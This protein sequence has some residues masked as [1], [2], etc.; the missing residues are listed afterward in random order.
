[1]SAY[2]IDSGTLTE[3]RAAELDAALTPASSPA[4]LRD[5]RRIALVR[6]APKRESARCAQGMRENDVLQLATIF[7][8]ILE[9]GTTFPQEGTYDVDRFSA[10]F[11]SHAAFV[12]RDLDAPPHENV[13][14]GMVGELRCAQCNLAIMH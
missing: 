9:E 7:D 6:V 10:Y 3:E 12:V 1:M 8:E 4:R 11:L 2:V 14:G 13:L 5:G